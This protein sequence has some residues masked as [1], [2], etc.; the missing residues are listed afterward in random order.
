MPIFMDYHKDL[1]VTV[2]DVKAAHTAD[3]ATQAKYKVKNLKYWINEQDGTMF[4]LM[5]APDKES[6]VKMHE[7]SHGNLACAIQEIEK[8]VFEM[9]MGSIPSSDQG[10]A[11]NEDGSIDSGFRFIMVVQITGQISTDKSLKYRSLSIPRGPKNTIRGIINR[12]QGGIIE[13]IHDDNITSVFKS[14]TRALKSALKIQQ[15]FMTDPDQDPERNISFKIGLAAGQ[16]LTENDGLHEETIRKARHINRFTGDGRIK[17]SSL[18]NKL[19][20][21]DGIIDGNGDLQSAIEILDGPGE[22]FVMH[23]M[24]VTENIFLEEEFSIERLCKELGISRP[25]L[26]RKITVLT[27]KAPTD[28]IRDLRLER[29][30]QLLQLQHGNV[31]EIAYEVGFNNLSYFSKCFQE[32][33]GMLPSQYLNISLPA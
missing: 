31:S 16:P 25:Q 30:F 7:A 11:K 6:C 32:K 29:A 18:F 2:E 14:S 27:G 12:H 1:D 19:C 15:E 21:I 17:V 24:D 10:V 3:L 22:R 5:E 28:W 13:N 26:Y 9:I 4:C 33:F 8:T 20:D 23:L